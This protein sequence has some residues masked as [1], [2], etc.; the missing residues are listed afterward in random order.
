[1]PFQ[2]PYLTDLLLYVTRRCNLKCIHCYFSPEH[3]TSRV[4]DPREASARD[5]CNAIEALLPFGLKA[6]KLTGGEPFLRQ[7]I[8]ELCGFIDAHGLRVLIETNGTLIGDKD[9]EALVALKGNTFVSV[10]IDGARETTH[11][12][13]RGVAGSYVAAMRG[14]SALAAAGIAV[15]VIASLFEANKHELTDLMDQCAGKGAKSFKLN[16]VHAVGRGKTL[17]AMPFEEVCAIDELL[18]E[19]AKAI[20][21]TYC[22]PIPVGM[23]PITRM[24][25]NRLLSS[26]C[27]IAS[28]I[29]VLYDGT[30]T[31]CG[32]GQYCKDFCYGNL[33]THSIAE[34]WATHP[35]LQMLRDSLPSRL[36]G[37]C[38]DCLL[39]RMCLGHCRLHA[40][41]VTAGSVFRAYWLCEEADKRGMFPQTRRRGRRNDTP[42]PARSQAHVS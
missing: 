17:A 34:V 37:I 8:H 7:D 32:M 24:I 31:T 22:S 41:E 16:L 19:H 40:E 30:I 15:Q 3:S 21:M 1:M 33:R 23:Q 35:T 14:A 4:A 6:V 13:I 25:D 10:S 42:S 27:N 38:G 39:R 29:S 9:V 18:A 20:A 28:T 26:R 12:G 11:D 36:E 5:F 2:E